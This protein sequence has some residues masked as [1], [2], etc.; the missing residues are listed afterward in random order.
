MI[1]NKYLNAFKNRKQILEG[2]K[3]KVFKKEH[4]EAEAARRWSICKECEYLDTEGSKCL[5]K[6]TQPCCGECGCSLGLKTRSLSS[7]CGIGK[8]KAVMEDDLEMTLK[9]A[10]NYKDEDRRN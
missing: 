6:G 4:I 3:N 5:V 7:E 9:D 10:L 1:Y 8:W 2:I